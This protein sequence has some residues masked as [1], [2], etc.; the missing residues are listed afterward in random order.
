MIT[1]LGSTGSI[2][3]NTLQVAKDNDIPIEAICANNNTDLLNE[4]IKTFHPKYVAINDPTKKDHIEHEKIFCGEEGILEMLSLCKS[5]TIINALVGF[6][7]LQPT[8][9][10]IS[11][12]KK[13]ALANKESLVAAGAFIDTSK[14]VPIDSEHFGLAYLLNG[15]KAKK[16]I[17]TASGGA[18][19]DTPTHELQ[20][21]TLSQALDHPNWKMGKKITIDSATMANKLF[22]LLEA[23]W[24]FDITDLDALIEQNSLVHALIEFIDGSTTAHISTPDMKL[25]I[26][27]A[28]LN[29][30]DYTVT[31]S[32]NLEDM[33]TISFKKI[34]VE[35]YPLWVLKDEILE[36][37]KKG[38]VINAAND[39]AVGLF[40][41]QKIDFLQ[42]TKIVLKCYEKFQ[43]VC[44][45]NI[46]E[47]FEID[48]EVRAYIKGDIF[49]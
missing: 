24:L 35:K 17:I 43:H 13:V 30:V 20:N 28:I 9:E 32:V 48:K 8:L 3:T 21:V 38:T 40:L 19:R 36:D 33:A 1:V 2:G 44:P 11:L 27:F 4:Q 46:H 47:V 10:A 18:F 34:D 15:R 6:S 42:I 14:I 45:N 39:R 5:Q 22:E 49:A 37:S 41:E 26:A 31:E 7:G 16:M 29:K 12:G 25:P 23:R